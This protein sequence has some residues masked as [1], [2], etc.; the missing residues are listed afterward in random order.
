MFWSSLEYVICFVK[1][2]VNID[3]IH[4]D[5][6]SSFQEKFLAHNKYL[7]SIYLKHPVQAKRPTG[8]VYYSIISF[9]PY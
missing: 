6:F 1:Y 2:S 8:V 9:I 4:L 5:D 7:K 3:N